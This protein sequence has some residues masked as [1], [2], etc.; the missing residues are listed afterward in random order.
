[1]SRS[2]R[3]GPIIFSHESARERLLRYGSVITFRSEERTTGETHARWNRT[4]TEEHEG[5]TTVPVHV[6]ERDTVSIDDAGI[7]LA[8]Y[9]RTAGFHS[10]DEWLTAIEDLHGSVERGYLYQATLLDPEVALPEEAVILFHYRPAGAYSHPNK[11]LGR[12]FGVVREV[13][14]T[15][16]VCDP[17]GTAMRAIEPGFEV[18]SRDVLGVKFPDREGVPGDSGQHCPECHAIH[19]GPWGHRDECSLAVQ[20][21]GDRDGE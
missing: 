20:T 21:R 12:R 9:H 3:V 2:Q 15:S 19:V 16:V 11:P 10:P 5:T 7:G 13:R 14:E 8:P 17:H 6:A 1:M 4:A 18:H